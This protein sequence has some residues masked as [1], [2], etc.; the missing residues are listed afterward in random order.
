MATR[1]PGALVYRTTVTLSEAH[2]RAIEMAKR[3]LANMKGLPIE[4]IK[5][6]E[7]VQYLI[8]QGAKKLGLLLLLLGLLNLDDVLG[9]V[10]FLL[11]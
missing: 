5:E 6:S 3:E 9:L 2:I 10:L 8:T 4:L 7:A 11:S 1:V